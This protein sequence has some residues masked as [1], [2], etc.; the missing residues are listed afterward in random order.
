[1]AEADLSCKALFV[2]T[3]QPAR[4]RVPSE[5]TGAY[6]ECESTWLEE[7]MGAEWDCRWRLRERGLPLCWVP[8]AAWELHSSTQEDSRLLPCL[9]GVRHGPP[10]CSII[11]LAGQEDCPE[12]TMGATYRFYYGNYPTSYT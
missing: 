8:S 1:M 11:W 4:L 6:Q 2:S 10:L 9:T 5:E 3:V 12:W 7:E